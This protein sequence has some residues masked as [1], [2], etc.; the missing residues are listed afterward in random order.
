MYTLC[1]QSSLIS[2]FTLSANHADKQVTPPLLLLLFTITP[3]NV[4]CK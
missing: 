3:E 4:H 1:R 2:V